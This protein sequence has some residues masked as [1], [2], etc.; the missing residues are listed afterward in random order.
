MDELY[1]LPLS[2]YPEMSNNF[3]LQWIGNN[4]RIFSICPT[5]TPETV[6]FTEINSWGHI[7]GVGDSSISLD[8]PNLI[9]GVDCT[10]PTTNLPSAKISRSLF[11]APNM[12]PFEPIY[13]ILFFCLAVALILSAFR[14]IFGR[15]YR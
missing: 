2:V 4:Y 5:S 13:F 7:V 1:Y 15:N 12:T 6:P 11:D 9:L 8:T 14:L 10:S 3:G